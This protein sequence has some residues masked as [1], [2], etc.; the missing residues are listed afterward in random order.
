ML[1]SAIALSKEEHLKLRL[2][3]GSCTTRFWSSQFEEFNIII[4]S[5][6]TYVQAF[7]A[8]GYSEVKEYEILGDD[9][10]ID[11]CAITDVMKVVIDLMVKV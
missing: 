5:F 7:R 1:S 10:V 9:F 6:A 2:S 4:Q 8:F 3:K 11:L